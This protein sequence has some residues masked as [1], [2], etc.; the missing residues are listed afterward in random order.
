MTQRLRILHCMRAP[1]G[2][3]F[4]HVLD[5]AG[6]QADAGH[7]V[8]ILADSSASDAMTEDRF[9]TIAPRLEL[10]LERLPMSRQPGLGDLWTSRAVATHARGLALDVLHGHGAKGGAYAR[11]AGRLLQD[12]SGRRVAVFYTPHGGTLNFPSGS[13]EGRVYH[14]LER[15][16]AGLTS[17]IVFESDYA[18]RAFAEKIG[19]LPTPARVVPNGLQPA[20][21]TPR[22]PAPD[23]ADFVFVGELRDLKGVDVM[24][25][26]LR[27]LRD[28]WPA[29]AV[30]VGSGPHADRF[31]ALA[32][33]LGLETAV[34]FPGA[35]PAAHAFPLGR[36]LVVPSLKESF[37]YVVLEGAAAGLPL[38]ATN[39]GGIPEMV[40]GTDTT[41]VPA[42]DDRALADQMRATILDRAAALAKAERLRA[43]ITSRFTVARMT[44]DI[45]DFYG[46]VRSL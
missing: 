41:L 34:R 12:G 13:L 24:L 37:P 40:A 23:A 1:V 2:G 28:E 20:D 3:L 9:S 36:T 39:V 25:R 44:A 16:L 22:P 38:V 27:R 43:A 17:G 30:L 18:R 21:L 5:L 6:E 11:L 32:R 31:K 29:T 33:D 10:G 4:R 8:G 45:L 15:L 7:A 42:G 35:M 26:A 14:R 19:T 46:A